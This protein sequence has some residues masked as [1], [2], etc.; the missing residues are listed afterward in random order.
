MKNC[1]ENGDR[2]NCELEFCAGNCELEPLC[3]EHVRTFHCV[4]GRETGPML[5]MREIKAF[6]QQVN[7]S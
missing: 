5:S 6:R 4:S 2:E 3:R 1:T 7:V